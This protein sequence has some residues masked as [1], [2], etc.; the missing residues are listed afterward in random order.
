VNPIRA[1]GTLW[2]AAGTAV[3]NAVADQRQR[4]AFPGV[5][6]GAGVILRGAERMTIGD[7]TFIDTRAYVVA[8]AIGGRAGSVRIGRACEIG[9][10]SVVWGAGGIDI[11][12]NVH[13]GAHVHIT[14]Q[15][16]RPISPSDD[17]LAPGDDSLAPLTID[18]APVHV[19][20][21][22]LIYSG[23]IIV[24]G[25]TIG[26]HSIIA[27]GAVVTRDVPP[28]SIA[29]GVPAR[30]TPRTRNEETELPR[31]TVSSLA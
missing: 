29:M 23:A 14:S 21:H 15:Q 22:V 5:V 26:P 20:D 6:F 8:G 25:I 11:G 4:D 13:L 12:N 24:P 1:F 17:S 2:R 31:A 30:V 9:P 3:T 16:G 18:C 10:Y 19:G 27:A 28:N 7:G